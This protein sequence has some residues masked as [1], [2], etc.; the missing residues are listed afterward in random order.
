[1]SIQETIRNELKAV[2]QQHHVRILHAVESG[3]R[4]WGI[5]SPDSDYDVRFIYVRP[6]KDYLRLQGLRDTIDWKLDA[7]LDING[8]DVRKAL[9]HFAKGSATLF[10][11]SLS[12]VVYAT[13]AQWQQVWQAAAPYFSEKAA[14]CH[15]YGTAASTWHT[16]LTGTTVQYKKYFYALRPLLAARYIQQQHTPPPVPF[17]ALLEQPLPS[18]LRDALAQL[19]AAKQA[20][21]EGERH[22]QIPEIQR[23]LSGELER[24]KVLCDAQQDDRKSDC[25]ALDACFQQLLG[26]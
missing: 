14:C 26:L 19:L 4:A 23:F 17:D 5:A 18:A 7:V 3:S 16:H 13:T 15:Y 21:T 9:Q 25:S 6:V 22:P 1:M 2:E 20:S 8:W 11:W 12:P 10:E 24:Q